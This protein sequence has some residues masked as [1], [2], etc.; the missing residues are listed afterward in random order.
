MSDI[1]INTYRNP[2]AIT[3]K[4]PQKVELENLLQVCRENIGS[5]NESLISN[6][7]KLCYAS[8]DGIKRAS[9]EPFYLHPLEVS[10]IVASEMNIDSVSVA[11]ALLHDTVE[12][13][14]V[15]LEDIKE[16][17]GATV[18]HLIDGVTKISG[19]FKS[20]DTK[21]A[22]TFMKLLLSMAEDLRV[23][24]IQFADRLH[25]MR[26]IEHL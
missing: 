18:A 12:D 2:E 19:V 14:D 21:Q 16:T 13:T 20:R 1:E 5:I 6:A 4:E 8:H 24:L 11:A 25:E 9:G 3:L 22:E 26:T 17:F 23:V 10:I 7:F 15:T